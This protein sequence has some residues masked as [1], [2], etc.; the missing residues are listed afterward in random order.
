[1][2]RPGT[3]SERRLPFARRVILA[4]SL[5]PLAL[6]LGNLARLGGA[7]Y[8]VIRL[9]DLP[10]SVSWAYLAAMGGVWGIV[11]IACAVGLA[12]F[13]AWGRW[14][15]LAATTLYQAH[16]W[17]NHLLFDA[18]DYA[19]LVRSRNLVLTAL[20]LTTVWGGLNWPAVRKAFVRHHKTVV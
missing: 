13:H 16:V 12:R 5:L 17:L 10:M 8:F 7:V 3:R 11:F 2:S 15:T 20:L 1:M 14:G 4:L 9:P 18:N 19:L 6:G